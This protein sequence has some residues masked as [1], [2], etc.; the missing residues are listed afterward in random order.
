MSAS[1]IP[2]PP[3]PPSVLHLLVIA[4]P[5]DESMFFTPTLSNLPPSTTAILSLTNGDYPP[6]S[7]SVREQ[8]LRAA[9]NEFGIASS[10]VFLPNLRPAGVY[11]HPTH[12]SPAAPIIAYLDDLLTKL[13]KS[14]KKDGMEYD[15][16]KLYTFDGTGVSGHVNHIDTYRALVSYLATLA[17]TQTFNNIPL[18]LNILHTIPLFL[19][20][21]PLTPLTPLPH[22]ILLSL[23]NTLLPTGRCVTT[24]IDFTG[25]SMK[26]HTSQNV[27]YRRIF[28]STSAYSHVNL[29]QIHPSETRNPTLWDVVQPA[30]LFFFTLYASSLMVHFVYNTLAHLVD[31]RTLPTN[32]FYSE[33][34]A[35]YVSA[36][37]VAVIVLEY[38]TWLGGMLFKRNA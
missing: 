16:I 10:R 20:Y 38:S 6:S 23:Y 37:V 11:D 30:G 15:E 4:H 3:L 13:V 14:E 26:C 29:L 21:S 18:S 28:V 24:C 27:W 5:D 19:K 31:T 1:S 33:A 32:A 12:R 25:N 36:A 7:G 22:Y 9:C 17:P 35:M 2:L 34:T 8:E